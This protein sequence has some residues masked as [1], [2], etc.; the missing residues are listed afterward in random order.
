MALA[1]I[2][3]VAFALLSVA[4]TGWAAWHFRSRTYGIVAGLLVLLFY[5]ALA[6]WVHRLA[7]SSGLA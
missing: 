7:Q 2:L 6:W 4:G 1:L 3:Y 5:V